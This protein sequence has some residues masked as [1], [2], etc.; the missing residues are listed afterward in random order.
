MKILTNE[1]IR[2]IEA[3]TIARGHVTSYDMMERVAN[4]VA[5]EAAVYCRPN[6]E[7]LVFAGWGNNGA[8][9]MAA[10]SILADKGYAPKVYLFNIGD[11]LSAEG[12]HYRDLLKR[13]DNVRLY[14]LNGDSVFEWPEPDSSATIIDGLFGSGLNRAL[15]R[16]F[17]LLIRN[18]N[19]SGATIISIDVP[20]GLMAEWNGNESRQNM[21]H[22]TTTIAVEFPR[23]S[24]MLA[25]N[26]EVVG[27]WKVVGVGYDAEAVRNAPV[28]YVL[29]DRALASRYLPKRKPFSSKHDY[30]H[31][32]IF[33]G[34]RGMMG[35]A[36]MAARGAL[37]S[38]A[39]RVTVH[40][41]SI[42]NPILQTV[43]PEAMF[44]CDE[45]V[46]HISKMEY[47]NRFNAYAVGPGIGTHTDTVVAFEKF[48]KAASAAGRRIV[49]DA[50]ALNIIAAHP[51]IL[52]YLPPLSIITP[53]EGEFDRI[54]GESA[55]S[56]ERLL[57]AVKCA[58]D[59]TLIIVLKGHHTVIVRP[60]GKLMFNSSGTPA[61]ATAGSGDVLTG[62]ITGLMAT[63]L[64]SE[65]AAFVGTYVHG[66]AGELAEEKHGSYGVTAGDIA[67]CVGVAIK[68]I[69]E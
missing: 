23:M 25:D 54:F 40:S 14:E 46:T 52:N 31:A 28:T 45:S 39:G 60:D 17:Q 4:A 2:K 29:I 34:S 43:V 59:Y 42:G 7:L 53:H 32:M 55:S 22:A 30:G 41:A 19:E 36:A 56:E 64:D 5:A 11:R 50:D 49:I 63:G 3:A 48:V 62:V 38:G 16:S 8:D 1:E 18:I 24:F 10:A 61:M 58:E 65:I 6:G 27:N 33:A 12:R 57:K 20:S 69:M 13:K 68:K 21:I 15:P 26:A 44:S 47:H 67:D 35:A 66:V 37:R 9:A 51:G